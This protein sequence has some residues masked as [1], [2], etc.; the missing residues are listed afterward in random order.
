MPSYSNQY[1]YRGC[2]DFCHQLL[3]KSILP[4]T[5]LL[6]M[7]VFMESLQEEGGNQVA[8]EI[9]DQVLTSSSDPYKH[10]SDSDVCCD[11]ATKSSLSSNAIVDVNLLKQL[12][13]QKRGEPTWGVEAAGVFNEKK[14]DLNIKEKHRR[15]NISKSCYALLP[16]IPSHYR[17]KRSKV[18]ECTMNVADSSYIFC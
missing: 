15:T 16:L 1:Q 17:A 18:H 10:Y 6:C 3:T 8:V 14:L 2:F 13:E 4:Y 7:N 9:S 5:D 11:L 12:Q